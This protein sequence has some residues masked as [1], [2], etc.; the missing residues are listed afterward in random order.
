MS[1]TTA[2]LKPKLRAILS[3][4][5]RSPIFGKRA[6]MSVYPG[7]KSTIT[8]PRGIR[9]G[10]SFSGVRVKTNVASARIIAASR[11]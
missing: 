2:M 10:R 5:S 11:S 1:G 4:P 7:T 9:T 6:A 3:I 8:R